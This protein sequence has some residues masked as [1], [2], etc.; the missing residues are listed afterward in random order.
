[1][2]PNDHL[3]SLAV[4]SANDST[5]QRFKHGAVVFDKRG[6]VISRG[7]N[8]TRTVPSALMKYYPKLLLHAECDAIVR[9]SREDLKGASLLVVRVGPNKLCNSKP[10]IHCMSLILEMEIGNVFYSD[11]NG[12][13]VQLEINDN[14]RTP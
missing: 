11:V 1:M 6:R 13:I 3:I 2:F 5:L 4:K 10:C 14:K 7:F 9:A 12:K 8:K